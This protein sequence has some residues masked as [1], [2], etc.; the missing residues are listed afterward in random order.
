[1]SVVVTKGVWGAIEWARSST[2]DFPAKL[3]FDGLSE[4]DR[5]KVLGLFKLF[6]EKGL[7]RN[8]EKFAK[9]RS[10]L[11]EFKC[12][13]QRFLG[14]YRPGKRFIVA[15]A[16][17]KKKDRLNTSDINKALRIIAE[18]VKWETDR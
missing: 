7:I 12:F 3:Y 16:L 6:S 17:Q 5:A 10:G 9:V 14:D 15:H 8:P 2:G 4:S 13:Q 18:H 1:M 11:F